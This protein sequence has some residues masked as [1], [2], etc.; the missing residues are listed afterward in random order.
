MRT[1]FFWCVSTLASARCQDVLIRDHSRLIRVHPRSIL[2]F[3]AFFRPFRVFRGYLV[4]LAPRSTEATETAVLAPW[5]GG[6]DA[7]GG[8]FYSCGRAGSGGAAL[9]S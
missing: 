2:F 7:L 6:I 4:F 8:D 5:V 1:V 9:A 3:L